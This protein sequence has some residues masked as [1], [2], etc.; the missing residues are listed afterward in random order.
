MATCYM[1]LGN[2]DIHL[3]Q[4]IEQKP[5]ISHSTVKKLGGK[6]LEFD[7]GHLVPVTD[8]LRMAI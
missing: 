4:Y 6:I 3:K 5:R 1:Y 8:N 7:K 2:T